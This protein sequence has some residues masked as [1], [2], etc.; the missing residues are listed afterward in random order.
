MLFLL[1]P[2]LSIIGRAADNFTDC[3][4]SCNF[5]DQKDLTLCS[6]KPNSCQLGFSYS[7]LSQSCTLMPAFNVLPSLSS[8]VLE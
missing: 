8:A 7:P 1:L 3:Y 6:D 5:C 2:L 4:G